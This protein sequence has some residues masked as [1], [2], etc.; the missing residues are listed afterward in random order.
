MELALPTSPVILQ[1]TGKLNMFDLDRLKAGCIVLC[2]AMLGGLANPKANADDVAEARKLFDALYGE[3]LKTARATGG[4]DDDLV[5][6]KDLLKVIDDVK[7]HPALITLICQEVYD[8]TASRPE[9]YATAVSAAKAMAQHVESKK[10]DALDMAVAVLRK[11][12]A[13]SKLNDKTTVGRELVGT[14]T[15]LAQWHEEKGDLTSAVTTYKQ[16]VLVARVGKLDN[17]KELTALQERAQHRH[18][19]KSKLKELEEQLLRDA[20]RSDIAKKL[21]MIHLVELDDPAEAKRF[22]VRAKDETL[23]KI[24]E[25]IAKPSKSLKGKDLATLGDWYHQQGK[26]AKGDQ[27]Y[28]LNV[29]AASYFGRFVNSAKK[30]DLTLAKAKLALNQLN[31]AIS[32]HEQIHGNTPKSSTARAGG[33]AKSSRLP[34]GRVIELIKYVTPELHRLRDQ[35][36][37]DM[38]A[39]SPKDHSL[40]MTKRTVGDTHYGIRLPVNIN[41]HYDFRIAFEALNPPGQIHFVAPVHNSGILTRGISV[42]GANGAKSTLTFSLRPGPGNTVRYQVFANDSKTPLLTEDVKLEP[43]PPNYKPSVKDQTRCIIIRVLNAQVHITSMAIRMKGGTGNLVS[44]V[45]WP[46]GDK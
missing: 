12:F 10:T 11:Q 16:A 33:P 8:T 7:E 34:V 28:A 13:R 39:K 6:C 25:L 32:G 9:G 42:K 26:L 2:L 21:V 46:H 31:K 29:K 37:N 18:S 43:K 5:V 36:P 41:G 1:P 45:D 38:W 35:I 23:K 27:R 40:T 4:F 24:V 20:S 30:K 14:L 19:Q 3:N 44:Q 22:V 15:E 17:L